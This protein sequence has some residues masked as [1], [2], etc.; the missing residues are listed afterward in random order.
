MDLDEGWMDESE[1]TIMVDEMGLSSADLCASRS[2]FFFFF[3]S[4]S[5]PQMAF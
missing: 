3:V 1:E 4:V 2:V 5:N